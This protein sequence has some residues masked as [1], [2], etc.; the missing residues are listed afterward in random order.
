M[1]SGSLDSDENTLCSSGVKLNED[2]AVTVA[3]DDAGGGTVGDAN[4]AGAAASM[5]A[6]ARV[7]AKTGALVV[8]VFECETSRGSN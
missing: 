4:S 1:A 7:E 6:G 2:T 5:E 8:I 3:R